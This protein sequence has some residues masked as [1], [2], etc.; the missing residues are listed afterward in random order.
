[1]RVEFTPDPA[2]YPFTSRW[3]DSSRGRA[4]YVDHRGDP[5]NAT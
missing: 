1:M 2:L 5:R 3:F 4:H